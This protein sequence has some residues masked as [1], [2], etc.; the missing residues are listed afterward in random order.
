MDETKPDGINAPP[1]PLRVLILEDDLRDAKLAAKVL[2]GAGL[3]VRFEVTD[4]DESFRA[5]LEKAEYDVILADFNLR[6][7]TALDALEILKQSGKDIPLIVVTGSLGDESAV[8]C[9]KRGAQDFVLKDRPA[10]LPVAVQR[11]LEEKRLREERKRAEERLRESEAGLAAAQRIAHIGSWHWDVQTD[12]A[13][14]SDETF[15][16][17]G[18]PPRQLEG[19]RTFFPGIDSSRRQDAGGSCPDRRTEWDQGLRS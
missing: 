1:P 3:R 8:E 19:H 7:W 5:N 14:W 15:R 13:H 18:L 17:F 10:R 6:N 12:T 16:I 9:V 4:S 2:E 11:A